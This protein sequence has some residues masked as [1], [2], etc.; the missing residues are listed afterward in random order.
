MKKITFTN[1][2]RAIMAVMMVTL[3]LVTYVFGL[4]KQQL[5]QSSLKEQLT[6]EEAALR[7][8]KNMADELSKQS[9]AQSSN[10][11]AD[12]HRKYLEASRYFSTLLKKL[13]ADETSDKFQVKN[14]DVSEYTKVKNLYRSTIKLE[15]E[16][17]FIDLG[18]F[19][20]TLGQADV[21]LDIRNIKLTRIDNDLKRCIASIE[22]YG[23]YDG[24]KYE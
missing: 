10:P 17:S 5:E 24:E 11:T 4:K 20:N 9:A 16:T 19:L 15:V 13:G 7:E 21:L 14:I 2:E 12:S 6:K 3:L 1:R 23:Y 8:R 18:N 22:V